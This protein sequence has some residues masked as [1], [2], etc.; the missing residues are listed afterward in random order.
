MPS[1]TSPRHPDF[2]YRAPAAYFVT[3]CALSDAKKC[4]QGC[5]HDRRC[6]FGTVRRGRMRLNE[7]GRIVAEEWERSETMREEVIL[8]VFV[9][10]P[11]HLHGIICLVPPDVD[12]VSPR[13][14]DLTVGPNPLS[15]ENA[16]DD[17]VGTTRRSSLHSHSRETERPKGPP[18][19]SLSA[20]LAGF[21]SAATKRINQHRG[22]P[23][24]PVW[25]SR[26][27]DRILRNEREWRACRRYV[28]HNPARWP[29]DRHHP[30][31]RS[32]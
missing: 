16:T 24:A 14:Y 11:N 20:I 2:D 15:T 7:I 9:T 23:G 31:R 18:S 32:E 22:T 1:R 19:Q 3:V 17:N 25:Q 21:K 10:M 4:S 8:D 29:R 28:E 5:A 30:A 27:H 12:D 13:G 26:H 6:L